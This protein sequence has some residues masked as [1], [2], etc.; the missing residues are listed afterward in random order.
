MKVRIVQNVGEESEDRFGKAGTVLK[1]EKMFGDFGVTFYSG[2]KVVTNVS[3]SHELIDSI[4]KLHIY[5]LDVDPECFTIFEEVEGGFAEG[6][7]KIFDKIDIP[8][9]DKR[10]E[11]IEEKVFER[12]IVSTLN[13]ILGS[14]K[15]NDEN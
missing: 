9:Y 2:D 5:L 11:K 1:M 3:S 13:K 4:E 8:K 6:I 7:N 12:I 15:N 10:L 14:E